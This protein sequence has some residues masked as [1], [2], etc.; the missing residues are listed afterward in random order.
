LNDYTINPRFP[1]AFEAA[2]GLRSDLSFQRLGQ[3]E[4]SRPR[5]TQLFEP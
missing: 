1:R 3:E 5:V 4:R 2:A